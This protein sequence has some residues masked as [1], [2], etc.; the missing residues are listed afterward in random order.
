MFLKEVRNC[1]VGVI[2]F[3]RIGFIVVKLFKGL[4]VNVIGYDMFFK[5][6]VEDI[7]I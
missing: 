7:V 2:G 1:I 5:I 3:G 4:G 6:G